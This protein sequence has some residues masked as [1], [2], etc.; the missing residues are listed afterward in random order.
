MKQLIQTLFLGFF[1]VNLTGCP[2]GGSDSDD[3]VP[4]PTGN[5]ESS[6]QT[7]NNGNTPPTDSGSIS[8]PPAFLGSFN[9]Q[10][11]FVDGLIASSNKTILASGD[12]TTLTVV[13]ADEDGTQAM[14]S[15]KYT[16]SSNCLSSGLSELNTN[17]VTN[18]TG[19]LQATYTSV[20]CEGSDAITATAVTATETFTASVSIETSNTAA[21]PPSTGG[22]TVAF[23]GSASDAGGFVPNLIKTSNRNVLFGGDQTTLTVIIADNSGNMVAEE[24]R[25][26][27]SSP[28]ISSGKSELDANFIT[29]SSGNASLTYLARGC[30]GTDTVS[31]EATVAGQVFNASVDLP[32]R[33]RVFLGSFNPQNAFVDGKLASSTVGTI[34]NNTSTSLTYALTDVD[35]VLLSDNARIFFSSPCLLEGSAEVD[36][37]VVTN[38]TGTATIT[39]SSIDCVGADTV[40]ATTEID[41]LTLTASVDLT[42]DMKEV[43][44]GSRS[45]AGVFDATGNAAFVD[46]LIARNALTSV[47]TGNS[48]TLSVQLEDIDGTPITSDALVTFSSTCI[49]NGTSTLSDNNITNSTGTI[50]VTYTANG[51]SGDDTVTASTTVNES[52]LTASVEIPTR[53]NALIGSYD[54]VGTFIPSVIA[55]SNENTLVAG[56]SS[57]LTLA[58]IDEDGEAIT[59]T[60]DIFFSSTC[61]SNGLAEL[62]E[63]VAPN[64]GGQAIVTYTA[65]GCDATDTVTAVTS[66]AGT[67]LTATVDIAT[68]QLPPG[69]IAFVAADK[70]QIGIEGTDSLDSQATVQFRV[71]SADGTP[72]PNQT[73][74]FALNTTVG[75][76]SLSP[77]I[78]NTDSDGLVS[79]TVTS[80]TVNTPVRVTATVN[81]VDSAQSSQLVVSTGFPHQNSMSLSAKTLNIEGLNY[82]GIETILT[83]RVSDRYQNPVADGTAVKF[84]AEGGQV[85]ASCLT[86]D[87][88]CSV[89]FTSSEPRPIDGRATVLAMVI[90][91][92]SF[93]D[94]SPSNG[95]HD[96]TENFDDI[97][98]VFLDSDE[99]DSRDPNETFVDFNEN[100]SFDA[101]NTQFDGLRVC[102]AGE[103]VQQCQQNQLHIEDNGS[104]M[105][106]DDIVIVMSGS[107]LSI[108]IT[109]GAIDYGNPATPQNVQVTIEDVNGQVP[110]AGT[111]Y[112]FSIDQ[113]EISFGGD[114]GPQPS[115]NG[116]GPVVFN[117]IVS[118]DESNTGTGFFQVKATTPQGNISQNNV[119][120]TQSALP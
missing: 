8:D 99:D 111:T 61:L 78:A 59:D 30:E 115:T 52:L 2:G 19:T 62:S 24:A 5:L 53:K 83:L 22:S 82:D 117:L 37:S 44:F 107:N 41:G 10:N 31:V 51:C 46:K 116:P 6:P 11:V 109:T 71:T 101:P 103:S 40:T 63:K 26:V 73:V 34:Y 3:A 105:V 98:E 96:S 29:N 33:K 7:A 65:R 4:K 28:C 100:G 1:V 36:Q 15:A 88:A 66:V 114:V 45:D 110:P 85:D 92:E 42:T 35:G 86:T 75:G 76:L 25:Y 119:T 74:E 90:G 23:A 113:G 72:V 38:S 20:G 120:V 32:T 39:Y 80:G 95:R 47:F 102:T 43:L 77:S 106:S 54:D 91:E 57:E 9:S 84:E 27:F 60:T 14:S 56:D 89:T 13:L 68:Q 17:R 70:N 79:T 118:P 49:S 55:S 12:S 64:A 67:T 16:F 50:S 58:I 21:P 94:V 87:G 104:L 112:D 93:E 48:T 97:S 69:S 81:G 18:S 108:V